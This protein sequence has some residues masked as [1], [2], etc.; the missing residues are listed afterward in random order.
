MTPTPPAETPVIPAIRPGRGGARPGAGRKPKSPDA[1][2]PYSILAKAKAKNETIK[3]ELTLLE[4]KQR[5]GELIPKDEV[6]AA[7]ADQIAIAKG[8]LLSLPSRV[9]GEVL[10]LKT[11]REIEEVIKGAIV[12]ILEELSDGASR[13]T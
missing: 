12:V 7:W 11:Q 4:Y 13:Y 8:R 9:S 3:A 1:S 5:T 2:D 10:R 6:A